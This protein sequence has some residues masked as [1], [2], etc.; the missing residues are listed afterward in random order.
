MVR[1]VVRRIRDIWDCDTGLRGARKNTGKFGL[2]GEMGS[3]EAPQGQGHAKDS[4]GIVGIRGCDWDYRGDVAR[5]TG[6]LGNSVEPREHSD[7][8]YASW[9]RICV[10]RHG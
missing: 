7:R 10:G 2:A 9:T 4:T 6:V 3:A 5:G 1:V 8:S